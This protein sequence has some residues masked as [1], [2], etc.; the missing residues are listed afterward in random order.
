MYEL[1]FIIIIVLP[2]FS[3]GGDQFELIQFS[4]VREETA[5]N[6]LPPTQSTK[7][8]EKMSKSCCRQFLFLNIKNKEEI[9]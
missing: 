4:S 6:I 9:L 7:H 1:I 3:K 5:Q 8:E 2:E